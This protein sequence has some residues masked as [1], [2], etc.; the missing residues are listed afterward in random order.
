LE[1]KIKEEVRGKEEHDER[2]E[3]KCI[4]HHPN[5]SQ[6]KGKDEEEDH[7]RGAQDRDPRPGDKGI[8]E[9]E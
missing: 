2:G 4:L 1:G 8:E 6:D 9:N 7:D 3:E 5:P